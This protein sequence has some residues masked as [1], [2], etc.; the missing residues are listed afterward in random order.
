MMLHL[1]TCAHGMPRRCGKLLLVGT[2]LNYLLLGAVQT[3]S[4]NLQGR[5][6]R[7]KVYLISMF[8]N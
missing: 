2:E 6:K 7:H 8:N 3:C 5:G 4:S 1:V